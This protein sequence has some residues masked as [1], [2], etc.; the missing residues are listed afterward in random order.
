MR[1]EWTLLSGDDAEML[2]AML[3]CSQMPNAKHLRPGQGDG[4]IDVFDPGPNG[5]DME[6]DVYQVKRFTGTLTSSQKRKIKG[7]FARVQATSAGE[8]W[9]I[10]AWNLVLPINPTPGNLQWFSQ[11]TAEAGFPCQWI[12]LT[13]CNM[14]A[15]TYQSMVDY[16]IH[17]GRQRLDGAMEAL[18]AVVAGRI[19]REAGQPLAAGHVVGD[20][21][22]IHQAVNDSDPF[23]RYGFVTSDRPPNSEDPSE[24][25]LVAILAQQS[26]SV[27][28]WTKI[29]A[30]NRAALVERPLP[31]IKLELHVPPDEPELAQQVQR[32]IDYGT[33]LEMPPGTVKGT[34][35]L[36]G[37]FGGPNTSF[38]SV[39]ILP[40][41]DT[42]TAVSDEESQLR[43]TIL[44]ADGELKTELLVDATERTRGQRGVRTVWS[45]GVGVVTMETLAGDPSDMT[46]DF[47]ISTVTDGRLPTEVAGS[48]A[49]V[50]EM[51]APNRIG[52]SLPFGPR[53]YFASAD[54]TGERNVATVFW[55]AIAQALVTIQGHVDVRL[56]M[57]GDLTHDQGHSITD[58]AKLLSG[59]PATATWTAEF[60]IHRE[61]SSL[62]VEIGDVLDVCLIRDLEI[63]LG[64]RSL[65]VG[66]TADFLVAR[67]VEVSETTLRFGIADTEDVTIVHYLGDLPSGRV[68]S[69]PHQS[70]TADDESGSLNNTE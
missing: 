13:Q 63:S 56:R 31:E 58:A 21:G 15:A 39:N 44:T 47:Q 36:P 37:G 34:I 59:Q 69:R 20:I 12:G 18:T 25:G 7:S 17:N 29:F 40:I 33:P 70:T 54:L 65:V 45:D 14:L 32:F 16:C 19:R 8:G 2:L 60:G 10:T 50:A 1:V 27:W 46:T 55:A 38:S 22:A 4:G 51:H 11:L 6:R 52:M 23:Y 41:N 48:L 66:K 3:L 49:F 61:A 9:R 43:L 53:R 24:P 57:P 64:D 26:N 62:H 67:V 5:L 30:R 35:E 28:V 42:G 68:L